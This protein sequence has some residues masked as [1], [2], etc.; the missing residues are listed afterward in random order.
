MW[1]WGHVI[2]CSHHHYNRLRHERYEVVRNFWE[3]VSWKSPVHSSSLRL[4]A[5]GLVEKGLTREEISS[6]EGKGVRL[7]PYLI[8]L[9]TLAEEEIRRIL[10]PRAVLSQYN[11]SNTAFSFSY[12]RTYTCG[13]YCDQLTCT[14]AEASISLNSKNPSTS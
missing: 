7:V 2:S 9:E 8:A 6:T 11:Y 5:Q 13:K 1:S 4:S 10:E 14:K 3:V 12:L